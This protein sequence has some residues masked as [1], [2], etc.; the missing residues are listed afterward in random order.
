[1]VASSKWQHAA[2]P[3]HSPQPRKVLESHSLWAR[4]DLQQKEP[5]RL[6]CRPWQNEAWQV[7]LVL[8]GCWA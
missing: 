6:G 2:T 3:K 5:A 8:H 1:M 4:V 7:H